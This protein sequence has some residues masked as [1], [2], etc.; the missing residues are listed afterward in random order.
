MGPRGTATAVATV[1]QIQTHRRE[2]GDHAQYHCGPTLIHDTACPSADVHGS[3]G[4]L[5]SSF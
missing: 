2:H 3:S 4:M 1:F 5:R